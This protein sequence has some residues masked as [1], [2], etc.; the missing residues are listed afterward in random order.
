MLSLHSVILSVFSHEYQSSRFHVC[1]MPTLSLWDPSSPSH[2]PFPSPISFS[3][4]GYNYCGSEPLYSG[5]SGKV[6]QAE[7]FIGVVYYQRLRYAFP[8]HSF[9]LL[10]LIMLSTGWDIWILSLEGMQTVFSRIT[11]RCKAWRPLHRL[12]CHLYHTLFEF[13]FRGW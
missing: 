12:D 2:S 13:L 11:H 7:I 6:M 1:V 10:C 9:S 4:A 8:Y 3:A 5:I